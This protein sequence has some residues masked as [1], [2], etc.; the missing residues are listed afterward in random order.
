LMFGLPE[1]APADEGDQLV[2]AHGWFQYAPRENGRVSLAWPISW[3]EEYPRFVFRLPGFRSGPH[4]RPSTEYDYMRGK[5]QFRD[6]SAW[7]CDEGKSATQ[8]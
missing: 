7:S 8:P 1:N 6:L 4:Y 3:F 5:Y 2:S